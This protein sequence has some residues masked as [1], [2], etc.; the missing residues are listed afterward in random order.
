MNYGIVE[1]LLDEGVPLDEIEKFLS[2]FGGLPLYIPK[3][4]DPSHA[5]ALEGGPNVAETLC[6]IYGGSQPVIPTG[7]VLQQQKKQRLAQKLKISGLNNHEIARRCGLHL[8]QVYRIVSRM[9]PNVLPP[10]ED[11]R[12]Q[13][14]MLD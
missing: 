2:V 3:Y 14:L 12:Q 6:R 5:I 11:P 7:M 1:T 4:F 10:K 13:Y 9:D 8:R